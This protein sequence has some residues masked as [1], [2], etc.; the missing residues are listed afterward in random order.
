MGKRYS[1]IRRF[2]GFE[3]GTELE[4]RGGFYYSTAPALSH[5]CWLS[6]PQKLVENSPYD[7]KELK[8]EVYYSFQK[9]VNG[10]EETVL[11]NWSHEHKDEFLE[12]VKKAL[13]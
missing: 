7:F 1:L 13:S 12:K 4:F 6:L 3:P 5:G 10:Q 11:H 2:G 8:D 9:R